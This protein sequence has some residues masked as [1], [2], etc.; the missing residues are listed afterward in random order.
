MADRAE[1]ITQR[2]KNL[3]NA[4]ADNANIDEKHE[5]D[6]NSTFS[7]FIALIYNFDQ[8]FIYYLLHFATSITV[9]LFA[10]K[11]DSDNED[12]SRQRRLTLMEEILLLGLKDREV[13]CLLSRVFTR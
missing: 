10:A 13:R 6:A 8:F 9:Y 3:P 11:S 2:R 12:D 5:D 4:T 1:G 7:I